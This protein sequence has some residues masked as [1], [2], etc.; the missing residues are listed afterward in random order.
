[1]PPDSAFHCQTRSKKLS[2]PKL[3]NVGHAL[4]VTNNKN[5][6]KLELPSLKKVGH[7]F[8]ANNNH[9]LKTVDLPV[10]TK[11]G[12]SLSFG[13]NEKLTSVNAPNL[14]VGHSVNLHGVPNAKTLQEQ[15]KSNRL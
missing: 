12:H 7:A 5:L 15:F 14:K 8:N 9:N 4:S 10:M 3:E 1:M 2:L 11:V 6:K 13:N